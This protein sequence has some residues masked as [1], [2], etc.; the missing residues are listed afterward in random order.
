[1]SPT[2]W[3]AQ[4]S[5]WTR[6]VVVLC[7]C[8]TA[9]RRCPS[10]CLPLAILSQDE[11]CTDPSDKQKPS[12]KGGDDCSENVLNIGSV[13]SLGW[14]TLRTVGKKDREEVF[15]PQGVSWPRNPT[16]AQIQAQK[17]R[18]PTCCAPFWRHF[19]VSNPCLAGF[20]CFWMPGE[21]RGGPT[22][23]ERQTAMI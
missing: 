16:C 7:R 22:N 19:N 18:C 15:Y 6:A 14:Q 13:L 1:M 23:E 2:P 11:K 10:P 20:L 8:G 3:R 9:A 17:G 21:G 12:P 4:I 5:K